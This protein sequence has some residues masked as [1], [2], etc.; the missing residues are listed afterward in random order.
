M[1]KGSGIWATGVGALALAFP[2]PA[3]WP[4]HDVA[5]PMD[6]V[7]V[8]LSSVDHVPVWPYQRFRLVREIPS[9]YVVV[10]S[11]KAG[12]TAMGLI[13]RKDKYGEPTC[14]QTNDEVETGAVVGYDMG[15]VEAVLVKGVEYEVIQ[16]DLSFLRVRCSIESLSVTVSVGKATCS[17]ISSEVRRRRMEEASQLE[18]TR[19][20]AAELAG[21]ERGRAAQEQAGGA[22]LSRE[23]LQREKLEKTAQFA[24][25]Q[26]ARGLVLYEEK[27]IPR[28]DAREQEDHK[29]TLEIAELSGEAAGFK[30]Q[31]VQM[32]DEVSKY[33]SIAGNATD[34]SV[35][36]KAL[37]N[38]EVLLMSIPNVKKRWYAAE[39]KLAQHMVADPGRFEAALREIERNPDCHPVV[40][41]YC[42]GF[43]GGR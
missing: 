3:E 32:V 16:G 23:R 17:V 42:R 38:A 12:G 24:D 1:G 20:R 25:A 5:I 34:R 6:T 8:S 28:E 36:T 41:A 35:Q 43:A 10:T 30:N 29:F 19:D 2:S 9:G 31:V 21:L 33:Q 22:G 15:V 40:S 37:K 11:N 27:W 4:V 26:L 39:N 18:A 13:P 7:R 14:I